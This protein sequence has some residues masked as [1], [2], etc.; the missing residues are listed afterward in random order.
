MD[1]IVLTMVCLAG[2]ALAVVA[3][4]AWGG[5]RSPLSPLLDAEPPPPLPDTIRRLLRSLAVALIAGG[6]A[7]MLTAG[8]GGRLMMRLLAATSDDAVQGFR[9]EADETIGRISLDGTIALV[10]FVGLFSGLFGGLV[11]LALRRWL[12]GRTARTAGLVLGA[13]ALG[14]APLIDALNRDSVDFRLL[15][16]DLLA[17]VAIVALFALWGMTVASF[18]ERGD[19]GWPQLSGR[20]T[21]RTVAGYAPLVLFVP[22]VG[23]LVVVL[24]VMGL[25]VLAQRSATLGRLWRS[26]GVDLAGRVVLAVVVLAAV[27]WAGLNAVDIIGGNDLVGT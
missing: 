24:A 27:G 18:V 5:D 16:P 19:R 10:L 1:V 23:V 13:V 4:V 11:Y 7:G 3:V 2:L 21:A 26:P 8:L 25:V 14:L 15:S 12:P 17:V 22:A 6:A 20:P 9:T